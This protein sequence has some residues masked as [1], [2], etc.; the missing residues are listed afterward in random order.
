MNIDVTDN[1]PLSRYEARLGDELVGHADYRLDGGR[2]TITHTE[3]DPAHG[4]RGVGSELVRQVLRDVADRELE[5]VPRCPFVADYL[6]RHP[7][8][9]LDLVAAPLR[10]RLRRE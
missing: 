9:F 10:E 4:G 8:S 7:D 5:L 6:R 3:V 1:R 2:L